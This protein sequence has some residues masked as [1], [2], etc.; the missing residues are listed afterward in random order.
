MQKFKIIAVILLY[1]FTISTTFILFFAG[2]QPGNDWM[3]LVAIVKDMIVAGV[4]GG[5]IMSYLTAEMESH[6]LQWKYQ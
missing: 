6:G 4:I 5:L 3:L 1:I 2:V